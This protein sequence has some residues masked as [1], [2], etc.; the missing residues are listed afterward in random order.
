MHALIIGGT[1][2]LKKTTEYLS[3]NYD[4]VSVICRNK[5]RID[6]RLKNINPLILDYTNYEA[7]S[8]NISEAM[9]KFGAIE[10]VV[11]WIHSTAPLAPKLFAEK[12]NSSRKP[13]RFFDILGSAYADPSKNNEDRKNIFKEYDNLI[14]RKII[15][16]FVIENGSSRWLTN[17]EISSGVID[18]VKNDLP[19]KIIGTVSPWEKRP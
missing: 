14:Y 9:E 7:L 5:N 6:A 13:F 11:S 17:D 12:I 15:L 3:E 4:T 16:G 2:M 18:A 10:L 8:G 19:E 1:G